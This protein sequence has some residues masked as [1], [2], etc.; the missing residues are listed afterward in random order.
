MSSTIAIIPVT[1]AALDQHIPDLARLRIQVFRDWPYLYAGDPAYEADY[2]STYRDAPGSV[3]VLALD[4]GEVVGAATALPLSS[5]TAALQAPFLTVGIDPAGVFYLGESVLLPAYRGRG[6]G[7]RFFAERE[8]HARR[9]QGS[10]LRW[11]AF[12]AVARAADDPRRPP[13]Y[14]PLDRFWGRRGSTC[15]PDLRTSFSWQEL[16]EAAQSPKPML[17]WLKPAWL[18]PACAEVATGS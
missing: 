6:I 11:F 2:L 8:A 15:R 7:V 10:Q 13:G 1:G 4:A 3:V 18:E 16:G 5:E 14:V 9:L 12:C 17:F